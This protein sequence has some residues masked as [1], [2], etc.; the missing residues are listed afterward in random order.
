MEISA[1]PP[2]TSTGDAIWL[3]PS[4]KV[5]VPVI[6]PVAMDE[7]AAWNVTTGLLLEEP[8]I[9]LTAVAVVARRCAAGRPGVP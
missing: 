7:T 5:I 1:L 3:E 9:D 6:V 8:D 2:L 4:K